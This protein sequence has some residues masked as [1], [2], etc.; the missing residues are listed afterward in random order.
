MTRQTSLLRMTVPVFT[1]CLFTTLAFGQGAAVPPSQAGDLVL[2]TSPND[3]VI[4]LT[5]NVVLN[6]DGSLEATPVDTGVCQET[7]SCDGVTVAITQFQFSTGT[8]TTQVDEGDSVTLNWRTNGATDCEATGSYGAWSSRGKLTDDS[9]DE[10]TADKTLNTASGDSGGSPYTLG[11]RCYNGSIE[12]TASVSLTVNEVTEPPPPPPP[13][14]CTGREP[15]SGWSHS[16]GGSA[17]N[18]SSIAGWSLADF[19]TSGIPGSVFTN[20]SGAKQYAA[21]RFTTTDMKTT[22]SGTLSLNT[23][24]TIRRPSTILTISQ[25]PGDFHDNQPTGCYYVRPGTFNPV[26][27]RGANSSGAG[28]CILEPNTTYYLN[29]VPTTSGA[30]T[31]PDDFGAVA[32]CASEYC[33]VL[34]TQREN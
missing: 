4:P 20:I 17:I 15:P 31:N 21:I 14:G 18:W 12:D 2:K 1:A 34:V 23:I 25:C 3:T 8:S 6:A 30:G 27:W 24:N 9:R 10:G 19:F 13:T 32:E 26:R 28:N 16:Y 11:L 7:Q 29:I 33:G 5:G 22:Q